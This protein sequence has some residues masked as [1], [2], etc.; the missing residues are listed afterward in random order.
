MVDF[1]P[2]RGLCVG[3][4]HFKHKNIH[5]YTRVTRGSDGIKITSM[6]DL[7]LVKRERYSEI[8]A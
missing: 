1:C 2:E 7:V 3:N 4:I 8:C 6:I 5:K